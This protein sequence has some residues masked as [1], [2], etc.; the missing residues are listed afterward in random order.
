MAAQNSTARAV[1]MLPS[2]IAAAVV[3]SIPCKPACSQHTQQAKSHHACCSMQ[4][5]AVIIS[6][7]CPCPEV[8][9]DSCCHPHCARQDLARKPVPIGTSPLE[10]KPYDKTAIGVPAAAEAN[11]ERSSNGMNTKESGQAVPSGALG[12]VSEGAILMQWGFLNS[13]RCHL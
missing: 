5:P 12:A 11:A 13:V 9:L 8:F 10:A 4:R 6:F 2:S 1:A 7:A 3:T